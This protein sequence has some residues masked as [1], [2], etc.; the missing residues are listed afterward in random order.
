MALRRRLVDRGHLLLGLLA[1]LPTLT[2]L[3]APPAVHAQD[4]ETSIEGRVVNVTPGGGAVGG[5][6]VLLHQQDQ[7]GV[8]FATVEVTTDDEG[9]FRFDAAEYDP[10]FAYGISLTY[11]DAIYVLDVDLSNGDPGPITLEVYDSSDDDE[12][13]SA[14]LASVLFAWADSADQTVST[15]E[16]VKIVNRSDH[17]YVPGSDVM[18]FLRFGLPPGA[19][20]LRV[21]TALPGADFIVVDKGFALLASIPPG[22]HEVMYTYRFPYTGTAVEFTKSLRYGAEL[23]RVL[24]PEEALSLSGRELGEVETVTIGERRYRLLQATGLPK[25]AQFSVRLDGLPEALPGQRPEAI[26]QS[27]DRRLDEVRFEYIAPVALGMLMA[28]IIGFVFWRRA[29]ERR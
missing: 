11:Q 7:G 29:N 2:A 23:L 12:A 28:S 3:V 10:T 14:S 4:Q 16:I 5:L 20:G 21:D 19:Q 9:R 8:P 25:G 27:S 13:L 6:T 26:V 22:E 15:L 18:G 24:A 1:L 17:T